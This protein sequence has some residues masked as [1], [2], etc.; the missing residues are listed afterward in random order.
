MISV[1]VNGAAGR[2]GRR[3]IALVGEA[4]D[5]E[6]VCAVEPAG[7]PALGEDA[8]EQAGVGTS[9][10]AIAED[11][12][13]GLDVLID[14]SSPEGTSSALRFCLV[15]KKPIVIGTTGFSDEQRAEIDSAAHEIPCLTSPN[16]SVGVNLLFRLAAEVTRALGPEYDVEIVETHHR[17]KKDAPSGTALRLAEGV[18]G[19]R[20]QVLSEVAVFGRHGRPGERGQGEIGIHAVRAGD[21]VGEH[22]VIFSSLGERVEL[23]HRAHTRDCFARGALVAARY[24]VGRPAGAY[25]MAD[26]LER[27]GSLRRQGRSGGPKKDIG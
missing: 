15:H 12:S 19:A 13:P 22:R 2:M 18:A 6:L 3:L 21:V 10:V 8:G 23:V 7:S 14:F 5:L 4:D 20:R 17:F 1:G 16:M 24:L 11:F 25:T 9:G 26:V 27:V